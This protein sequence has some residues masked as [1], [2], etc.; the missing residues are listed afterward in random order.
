MSV[1]LKVPT[2]T[3]TCVGPND[4]KFVPNIEKGQSICGKYR[5]T[6]A[7]SPESF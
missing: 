3:K 2:N 6:T 1:T 7:D 5:K 4:K